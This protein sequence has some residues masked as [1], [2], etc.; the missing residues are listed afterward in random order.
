DIQETTV[1]KRYSDFKKLHQNLW[2]IHR[3]LYGQSELFPLFAKAKVFGRFGESVIEKR[4]QCSEDLLQFSANIP[5][6]YGSQYILEFF[7]VCF[8]LYVLPPIPGPLLPRLLSQAR[9]P[10][11]ESSW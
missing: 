1:W 2:Q 7:K 3:N 9:Q 6:L 11:V 4:R 8:H 10:A 5:A